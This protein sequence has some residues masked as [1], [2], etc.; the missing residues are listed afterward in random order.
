MKDFKLVLNRR[1]IAEIADNSKQLR[2][3]DLNFIRNATYEDVQAAYVL[4]SLQEFM[5]TRNVVP[6]FE[7]VLSE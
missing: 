4:L 3:E 5:K 6:E 2:I 1:D 7:V